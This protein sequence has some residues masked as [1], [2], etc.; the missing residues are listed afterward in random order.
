MGCNIPI[1]GQ[2]LLRPVAI[3]GPKAA[4]KPREPRA[5]AKEAASATAATAATATL[6]A[7]PRRR[8]LKAKGG[9][10]VAASSKPDTTERPKSAKREAEKKSVAVAGSVPKPQPK[11]VTKPTQ[12]PRVASLTTR[13]VRAM[14]VARQTETSSF[15]EEVKEGADTSH[16][17]SQLNGSIAAEA[18]PVSR[19]A[20][21][22]V[23][24]AASQSTSKKRSPAPAPAPA[25]SPAPAAEPA[26]RRHGLSI[27]SAPPRPKKPEV[28][29]DWLEHW[30]AKPAGAQHSL[31]IR[32]TDMDPLQRQLILAEAPSMSTLKGKLQA[33]AAR[34]GGFSKR[35]AVPSDPHRALNGS[36]TV[37]ADAEAQWQ[38]DAAE[39]E[40]LAAR[41]AAVT[42]DDEFE[43]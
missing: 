28:K 18:E 22:R 41:V 13:R 37:D 5:P 43:I 32:M 10:A 9:K 39:M 31:T 7:K 42:Q 1:A 15:D 17:V 26:A 24:A 3:R 35:S 38:A 11:P 23:P 6:A 36:A 21:S 14:E 30:P 16:D 19:P 12:V 40:R 4:E 34:V 2:C 20:S 33:L 27:S 29:R 25:P 8:N